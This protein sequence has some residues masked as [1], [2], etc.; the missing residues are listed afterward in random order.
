[1][2]HLR[3]TI[4]K[5]RLLGLRRAGRYRRT[6]KRDRS[7]RLQLGG[8][9][10]VQQPSA[11]LQQRHFRFSHL[12][13]LSHAGANRLRGA[14]R[15]IQARKLFDFPHLSEACLKKRVGD[16]VTNVRLLA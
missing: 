13:H 1:M 10:E 2:R 12:E 9:D 16:K 15:Y 11:K 4:E 7:R 5:L 6:G 3:E 14:L 8:V